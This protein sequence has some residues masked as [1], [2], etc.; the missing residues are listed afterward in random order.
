MARHR[1]SGGRRTTPTLSVPLIG[2]GRGRIGA[3]AFIFARL[4]RGAAIAV[5][6][7]AVM[8]VST[9]LPAAHAAPAVSMTAQR[10]AADC[11]LNTSG[12]GPVKPWVR[13]AAVFL[14]CRFGRPR[15][16]GVAARAGASDHPTGHAVDFM[17]DRATGDALAACALQ[18]QDALGITYVIWRQRINFGR[19]WRGMADRGSA[20]ANHYDHVHIS[21]QKSPPS[22]HPKTC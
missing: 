1:S 19:G 7:G 4:R 14:G 9:Q 21:F 8:L 2:R 15:M 20:T 17:V 12:L 10:A 5:A 13:E 22:G 3:P 16:I 6:G 18:N 11:G